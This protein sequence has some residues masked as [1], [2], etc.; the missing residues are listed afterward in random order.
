M[1]QQARI[2]KLLHGSGALN[3]NGEIINARRMDS[4]AK[5]GVLA[6]SEAEIFV[7][8]PKPGYQEWIW[9]SAAGFVVITEA[10]G[11]LTDIDG[12]ELDFSLGAKLPTS[13][14][15][16]AM[17]NGGIFHDRLL[18]AFKEQEGDLKEH[19]RSS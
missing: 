3:E 4:Q 15:G 7:R 1:G 11:K 16:M 10:G 6:R 5:H 18:Q 17:S 13:V 9:D 8:L 14:R 2:A 12:N 19:L